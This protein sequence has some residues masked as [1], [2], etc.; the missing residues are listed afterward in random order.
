M[1]VGRGVPGMVLVVLLLLLLT[2]A[3]ALLLLLLIK[4]KLVQFHSQFMSSFGMQ[5]ELA[6]YPQLQQRTDKGW[7]N[8]Q[9][10]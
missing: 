2:T 8:E 6:P 4:M 10:V 1:I 7:Q 3:A 5:I 9:V